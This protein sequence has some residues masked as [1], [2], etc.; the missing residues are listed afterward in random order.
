[1]GI[2]KKEKKIAGYIFDNEIDNRWVF[3][4]NFFDI[5]TLCDPT[6]N[7]KI[8]Q[9][10][11]HPA[12]Y[13]NE[14]ISNKNTHLNFEHWIETKKTQGMSFRQQQ[15]QKKSSCKVQLCTSIHYTYSL[16]V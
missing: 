2:D 13:E 8:N 1:V 5:D 14:V 6:I 9:T 7:P 4:S 16:V 10:L 11:N 3:G 12:G 15:C